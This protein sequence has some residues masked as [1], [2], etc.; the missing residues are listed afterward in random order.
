MSPDFRA[1]PRLLL[2]AILL[3]PLL[4][5]CS[6]VS[7]GPGGRV[8]KVKHQLLIPTE[9]FRTMDRAIA[10][11]RQ[12]L[13]FGA[14]SAKEQRERTGHYYAFLWKADDRTQPVTIRFDYR[15]ADT[16]LEVF[17]KEEVV[18]KVKSSNWTKLQVTGPEYFGNGRVTSWKFTLLQG[19]QEIAS[20]QSYLWE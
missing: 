13:L 2:A 5:S 10:F 8:S 17:T 7:K 15:Q 14:V 11:E 16:G 9:R 19:G 18:T 12:Y 6:S 20:Q 3:A 4:A 1:S